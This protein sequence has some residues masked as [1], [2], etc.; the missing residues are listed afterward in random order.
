[1]SEILCDETR[2]MLSSAACDCLSSIGASIFELLPFQKRIYCLTNLLHLTKS[3]SSLIRSASARALGVYVTFTSLKE[4]Q[5]FLNDLSQCLIALL[6]NDTNNLVRQKTA[7]SLS[8]L[9]E[10]LVENGDK[11]AK[12]FTDEFSLTIWQRLLD[13]AS[14]LCARE[15]DKLK[16]YL[17]RTL[18]NLINYI[19]LIDI[20][21]IK[22]ELQLEFVIRS[23][24][25]AIEALCSCK[26]VKMLKVKWNLSHAIGVAMRQFNTW[27]L[28]LSNPRWLQM[29]YDTL[30][31]LFTL[32]NNFKV[33]INACIAMMNTNLSRNNTVR[34]HGNANEASIYF[35]MWLSLVD[36]FTKINNENISLLDATNEVQHKTTLIHQVSHKA[37][38]ILLE[39]MSF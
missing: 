32:S 20:D 12:T 6:T 9:S 38:L 17:V 36:T 34:A 29:F 3:Q 5:T 19:T 35:K 1:M 7:W 28:Q 24:T 16:S 25:K 22:S 4:D 26:H 2:Y 30:L 27:D 31:E 11:L 33:R 23:I 14:N 39:N 37:L 21:F 10:V 13:T 8:N 15:S 18:G